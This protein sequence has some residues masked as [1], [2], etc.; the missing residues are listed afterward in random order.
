MSGGEALRFGENMSLGKGE[1]MSVRSL[2]RGSRIVCLRGRLW[3]TLEGDR[4]DHILHQ[5]D[6]LL[7]SG[8]RR[9][10]IIYSAQPSELVLLAEEAHGLHGIVRRFFGGRLALRS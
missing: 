9:R 1:M 6:W 10:P 5:G 8:S 4:A 7:P 2:P 3:V